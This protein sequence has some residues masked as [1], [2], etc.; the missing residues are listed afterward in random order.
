[1]LKGARLTVQLRRFFLQDGGDAVGGCSV[2]VVV[3]EVG[4]GGGLITV[5][6]GGEV[7]AESRSFFFFL[8]SR[9][10]CRG[11]AAT[12]EMVEGIAKIT[13]YYLYLFIFPQIP[14]F[15]PGSSVRG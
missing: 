5:G 8:S 12:T 14:Q 11:A 4:V 9:S 10:S 2:V 3:G 13:P 6:L 7:V 1:M 15:D